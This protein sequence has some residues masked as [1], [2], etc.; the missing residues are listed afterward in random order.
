[1]TFSLHDLGI[2]QFEWMW[3]DI[4]AQAKSTEIK[5]FGRSDIDYLIKGLRDAATLRTWKPIS[6]CPPE[7]VTL[8]MV[9]KL[10]SELEQ[11]LLY[12]YTPY[13][14]HKVSTAVRTF[15]SKKFASMSFDARLKRIG[16]FFRTR[17]P[18]RTSGRELISDVPHPSRPLIGAVP[19]ENLVDL[20]A[21][22]S[23]ILVGDL[24][25]VRVTCIR[26][27]KQHSETLME[28][29]RLEK[30]SLSGLSEK[31]RRAARLSITDKD[32]ILS[33][34]E[35]E[36]YFALLISINKG[37]QSELSQWERPRA[38]AIVEHAKRLTGG[39]CE[40]LRPVAWLNAREMPPYEVLLACAL[41]IQIKTG[42]NF[43][44]VL[45]LPPE[46]LDVPSFP[47][48]LKSTKSRT[49]DET[50]T[51]LV[52]RNDEDVLL[53]L[54]ILL[55]RSRRLERLGYSNTSV[56]SGWEKT[57]VNGLKEITNWSHQ[58]RRF[59][60]KHDLPTFSLEMVRGQ[61]LAVD[62]V[63]DGSIAEAQSR[64]GH[65]RSTT[66]FHYINKAVLRR[67]NSANTLEFERRFDATVRYM[68]DPSSI[69]SGRKLIPFPIGDG[70]SCRNPSAPPVAGWL[71]NGSCSASNC[72][73]DEGCSNM[74]IEINSD[75]IEEVVLT[76]KY[77]E[78]NWRRLFNSNPESFEKLHLENMLFAFA[79]F[80]SISRGPYRHLL[81]R[82][83]NE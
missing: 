68:S 12:A 79:L 83:G 24:E 30:I 51:V 73:K 40:P 1:M 41:V 56:W 34:E 44:S 57:S 3:A 6:L 53:A 71:S 66:T 45:A 67:L 28:I 8:E 48:R 75:R 16:S 36:S 52:E 70:S 15:L 82:V 42:W 27:M 4:C 33:D 25:R 2:E 5:P 76:K 65:V 61:V 74:I 78:K 55:D 64:A 72:H 59:C 69:S 31:V 81:K 35:C 18:V 29:A 7:Q 38:T 60:R 63:R 10:F 9:L 37:E 77:F 47:H 32:V 14:A 17:C 26:V 11:F 13:K 39:S 46:M 54:K 62:T 20:Q 22:T 49:K 58:C 23:E 19:H 43:S 21:K 80:G 50:P